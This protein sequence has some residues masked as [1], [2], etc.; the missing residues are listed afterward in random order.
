M[1]SGDRWYYRPSE[2]ALFGWGFGCARLKGKRPSGRSLPGKSRHLQ[3]GGANG[4]AMS[5]EPPVLLA[6][7]VQP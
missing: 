7:A 3:R 1:T 5:F 6:W 4:F 2:R